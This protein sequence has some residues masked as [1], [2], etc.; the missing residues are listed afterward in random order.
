VGLSL[1]SGPEG[2]TAKSAKDAKVSPHFPIAGFGQC[3][4]QIPE[5]RS[6]DASQEAEAA[7]KKCRQQFCI[8]ISAF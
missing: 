3:R 2:E 4:N 7:S 6:A 8:L 1:I 5:I